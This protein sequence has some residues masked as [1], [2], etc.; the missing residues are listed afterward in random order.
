M[1]RS[2]GL[3]GRLRR[4]LDDLWRA[5]MHCLLTGLLLL[6]VTPQAT[7]GEVAQER[8]G[9]RLAQESSPYLRM[10]A[11]NPVEWFP[12]GE[13]AFAKAR[14]ENKPLFISIGYFTCHWCHVMARE[15]FSNPEIAAV[16]NEDFVSI[17]IDREQRPDLDDAYMQFVTAMRGQGGWPLSVW[18]TPDGK[19]FYGG[20]YFPPQDENGHPGLA[21]V[22]NM[23]RS[24]WQEDREELEMDADRN[25]A[26]LRK[27][28]APVKPLDRLTVTPLAAARAQLAAEYDELS[29]G[30]G[31]APKF[32]QTARL[33]FLLQDTEPSGVTMA[34]HTLDAMAAGGIHDQL[35]GGFHRYS[36]DSEWRVPHFEMM[37]YDQ[38]LI[39]RAYLLA[40]RSSGRK[41]YATTARRVLDA[42]LDRLHDPGGGFYS[43]LAADS[44]TGGSPGEGVQEG[45]FYVWSWQQVSAAL[46][47]AGLLEWAAA[48]YGL[49]PQ[50]EA[51]GELAGTNVLHQ[52]LDDRTLA[53]RFGTDVASVRKRNAMV[54]DRLRQVRDR[55][56]AV[57]VDDKVITAWNGY[58]ITT[59][60]LAGRML[61]E[62]RYIEEAARTA[63]FI[64]D[65]LYDD[66]GTLYRDWR[67]GRHGVPGFG[68]DYAAFA[69]G[70]LMLYRV[71]GE[72]HWL[73]RCQQLVDVLLDRFQDEE[74]GGFFNTMQDSGL[75]LREK[76]A[77]DDAA[78]SVNGI[79]IHVLLGIGTLTGDAGY[80]EEA[81]RTARWAGARLADAPAWMP[82]TLVSW[83]ELL[84][85]ARSE[86]RS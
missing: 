17:K 37:L 53:Q 26:I 86:D 32:P 7:D 44:P 23:I 82:Y 31:P 33:L 9:W 1:S 14:H 48:R 62:T 57:P 4:R 41:D 30:F 5:G 3:R 49:T 24:A 85:A 76:N 39:A 51:G 35:G 50:G 84:R 78:L 11:G 70:L 36:T 77:V 75:W 52:V 71:T 67:Q 58:M 21:T 56:P 65:K 72:K 22:L 68:E 80:V 66:S 81:V 74:H 45:A 79:A 20:S 43:A 63:R 18:A 59:L 40:W 2:T 13:A 47:D 15:S 25:V 29:G 60:A 12:W 10:H 54:D 83:P 69:E 34:L 73:E 16:L 6:P 38:A 19:P 28:T 64:L 27:R 61:G 55:R 42:A 46:Q 8:G